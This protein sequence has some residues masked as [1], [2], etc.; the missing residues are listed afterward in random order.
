MLTGSV[1]ARD[2]SKGLVITSIDM[3]Q[4]CI[5]SLVVTAVDGKE[6]KDTDP[7]GRFEF[8]P[9]EHTISAYGGGNPGLCPSFSSGTQRDA[10]N[11]GRIAEGTITI[12][13]EAGQ[14]YFV[15]AEIGSRD[16]EEWKI[17][18]WRTKD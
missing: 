7:S 3:S 9:G 18:V 14:E 15:G 12:D 11:S 1:A 6:L 8:E 5:L 13:V 2:K 17:K 16:P 10:L 4:N